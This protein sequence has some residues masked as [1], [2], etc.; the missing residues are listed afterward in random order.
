[1]ARGVMESLEDLHHDGTTSMM[2][3]PDPNLA[4]RAQRN[5]HVMDGQTLD[6][7]EK[8]RTRGHAAQQQLAA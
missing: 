5:I 2:M 8:A 3:A 6:F 1:M 7:A 4:Q